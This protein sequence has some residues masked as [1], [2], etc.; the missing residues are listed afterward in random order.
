[1]TDRYIIPRHLDDPEL[2]GL[3]TIDEFAGMIVPFAWGILAQHIFIGIGLA[4]ATWYVL[5]KAKAGRAS[6]WVLHAAYWYLPGSLLGLKIT[7]PSHCRLLA[8]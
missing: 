5:R 3:W 8:G 6:A 7:P 2:I 1:M 4:M